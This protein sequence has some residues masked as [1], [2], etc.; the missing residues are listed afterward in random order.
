MD[1]DTLRQTLVIFATLVMIVINA[2][3]NIIPI[4]GLTTAEIS[5]QFRVYFVPA[6]YVFAIWGLIYFA[7]ICFTVFQA[8]PSQREN[9]DLRNT[10]WWYVACCIANSAWIFLWHYQFFTL[11]AV[12]MIFLLI[13]LIV[14][15][16]KLGI[17]QK[18]V[19]P[20]L[21]YF[22]HL[23]FSIYLGWITVA[24]IA[25]I[26]DVLSIMQWNGFNFPPRSW[27]IIMMVVS[28][29]IAELVAYNKGDVAFL[30]VLSWS[31]FGIGQRLAGISTVSETA[32]VASIVIIIMGI[33]TIIIR[34]RQTGEKTI[35]KS[36]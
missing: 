19:N 31:F 30:L 5:D 36:Y 33:L 10:G 14:I 27:A 9:A 3:A 23:P 32:Y 15:Y 18:K 6:G 20:G 26:T 21:R 22:V 29:I 13:C 24:T 25:N 12:M 28:V 35:D 34:S 4:N 17:G 1:K 8:L 11:T 16:E 2:L 7:L